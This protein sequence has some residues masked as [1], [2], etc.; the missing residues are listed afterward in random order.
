MKIKIKEIEIQF[1]ETTIIKIVIAI[2]GVI[3]MSITNIE[4]LKSIFNL[5]ILLL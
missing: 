1:K 5:L 2:I 4:F 3:Y